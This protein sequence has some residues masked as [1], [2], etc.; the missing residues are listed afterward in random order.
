M[1]L[2]VGASPGNRVMGL[3]AR[4]PWPAPPLGIL[5]VGRREY[6]RRRGDRSGLRGALPL[7]KTGFSCEL[8]I[9]DVQT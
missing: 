3:I 9:P 2:N 6:P 5:W 8:C 4:T 7:Q 1:F